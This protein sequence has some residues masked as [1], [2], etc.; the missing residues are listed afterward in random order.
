M[1]W[2]REPACL[3]SYQNDSS[4]HQ[5]YDEYGLSV[6]IWEKTKESFFGKVSCKSDNTICFKELNAQL[7]NRS[8]EFSE[9][10]KSKQYLMYAEVYKLNII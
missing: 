2:R 4:F 9:E 5:Y 8:L 7:K 10:A 6:P 3:C 1:L